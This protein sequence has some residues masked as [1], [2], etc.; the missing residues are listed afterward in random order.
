MER[1]LAARPLTLAPRVESDRQ[2]MAARYRFAMANPD[3]DPEI[4]R[5]L[6]DAVFP[7]DVR[8]ALEREPD[9]LAGAAIE[10]AVHQTI[11]AR[12]S[13]TSDIVAI[14]TRSV[15]RRFVN[16]LPGP[17]G[18]LSQ[19]RIAPDYR[20]HRRLLD[21]GFEYCRRLHE[22]GGA[23]VYLSSVV[24][25]NAAA[26]KLLARRGASWPKFVPVSTLTTL[27]IPVRQGRESSI[28]PRVAQSGDDVLEA[29]AC[30]LRNGSRYQFSPVWATESFDGSVP[31]LSRSA[32]RVV[33]RGG[34][35]VGCAA[36]WDQ[37]SCRQ[38]VVRGY[39]RT[40]AVSRWLVNA[41]A[42][43]T[44]APTLP[45][46]GRRLEFGYVSHL[47]VDDDDRDVAFALIVSICETA[48]DKGL[49]YVAIG[50]PA[51]AALT[52]AV[53][54]RFR[55]RAYQSVLHIAFWPDGEE[56]VN[57]LDSRPYLPE[58]GTL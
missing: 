25:D 18:Y 58:L 8:I 53:R 4:R 12:H 48:R 14:A 49:D 22:D 38:I 17:V 43:W 32:L 33:E 44:G 9:A 56:I 30:L 31:G 45:A 3:D 16:G 41:T 27:A 40:L 55:H 13:M 35:V 42:R 39:C 5:L 7:G 19:L 54:S 20:R 24:S 51:E 11:V 28:R 57:R 50:L 1:L 34:R 26:L 2:A 36:L 6:R 47:A 15:R 10:G 46:V 23:R 37:R 21:A 29:I 52:A